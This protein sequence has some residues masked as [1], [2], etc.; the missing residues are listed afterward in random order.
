MVEERRTGFYC[1]P[2]KNDFG[3]EIWESK[4]SVFEW[5]YVQELPF[6]PEGCTDW[7]LRPTLEP[8]PNRM[9]A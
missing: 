5:V 8:M 2:E 6:I 7:V 4:Y 9:A 1:S 3:K